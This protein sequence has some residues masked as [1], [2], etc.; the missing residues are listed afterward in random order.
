MCHANFPDGSKNE[1]IA[2]GLL[3]G[4]GGVNIEK[5]IPKS[6]RSLVPMKQFGSILRKK[7]F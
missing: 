2:F 7:G 6:F 3:I 4:L 5:L 1:K